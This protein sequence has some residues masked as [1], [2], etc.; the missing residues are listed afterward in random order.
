METVADGRD[1]VHRPGGVGDAV[2]RAAGLVAP[3]RDGEGFGT[4][5]QGHLLTA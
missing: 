2:P 1:V 5:S 3:D 4:V